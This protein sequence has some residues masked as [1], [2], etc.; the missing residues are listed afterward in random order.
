[1]PT[2]L[3]AVIGLL[4]RLPAHF[5]DGETIQREAFIKRLRRWE[6]VYTGYLVIPITFE[7]PLVKLDVSEYPSVRIC[8]RASHKTR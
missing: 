3:L 1:V 6:T 4:G 7:A 5:T 8:T 2:R